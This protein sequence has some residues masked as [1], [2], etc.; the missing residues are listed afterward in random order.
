MLKRDMIRAN[1][2][3]IEDLQK[4]ADVKF[5]LGDKAEWLQALKKVR[6]AENAMARDIERMYWA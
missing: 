2:K 1:K 4:E 6:R 5:L 3:V